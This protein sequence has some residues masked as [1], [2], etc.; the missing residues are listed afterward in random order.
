MPLAIELAAVRL[1]ALPLAGLAN[2]L[3]SGFS[4]L[5]VSRR[6]GAARHQTMRDAIAWSHALC[7][8]AEKALWGRLSVFAGPFDVA[9]AEEVC[10]D[11]ALPR[12]EV[13]HALIGLVDKSV[14]LRSDG[15]GGVGGGAGAGVSDEAGWASLPEKRYRLLD[16]LREF[17][18]A[19]LTSAGGGESARFLDRLA[20]R[21]LAMA[22][23]FDK[24]VLDADQARRFRQLSTE[25]SNIAAALGHALDLHG[26]EARRGGPTGGRPASAEQVERWRRGCRLAVRLRAYWEM[27]GR[28]SEGRG[29]LDKALLALP[30]PSLERAWALGARGRLA[31]FQGDLVNAVADIRES[32]RLAREFDSELAGAC[33]YLHLNLALTFAGEHL[34]ALTAGH[35]ARQRLTECGPAGR[36]GLV[37]LEAQLAHLHQLAGDVDAA[38]DCCQRGLAKLSDLSPRGGERWIT[39]QLD[40][41]SGLA[42]Y[43]RPGADA[44]CEAAFRR[45]LQAKHHLGD[46]VGIAYCLEALGW[47]AVRSSR[48]DRTAWLLGAADPLWRRAGSRLSSIAVMERVHQRV[49][50]QARAALGGAG[51]ETAYAQGRALDLDAVVECVIDARAT[52]ARGLTWR[53]RPKPAV[54]SAVDGDGHREAD[55]DGEAA[56]PI[57]TALLTRRER[58]IAILVAS[59]L[60]NR[61][62]AARLF[63]SKRTVD[64]HVEHIFAKLEISSRVKLTLWL[65]SQVRMGA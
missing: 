35:A 61:E 37:C 58:E 16:T 49:G 57:T 40:L 33:G 50:E 48:F 13:V 32:I 20:D 23:H 6:G 55:Q 17:G 42:L 36:I 47:L 2:L 41:I 1:R 30:E 34:Q 43:Q 38:L 65:R 18:A 54:G 31:T 52:G 14:V 29:Y 3:E 27:S 9:A 26:A 56:P 12:N 62:I 53:S 22:E 11:E 63:I 8:P 60:S 51:Y 15:T 24:H 28:L 45:A 7:T 19:E 10:A 4:M 64:A 21:Y 25:H 44:D 59:G 39:S 46:E 5:G